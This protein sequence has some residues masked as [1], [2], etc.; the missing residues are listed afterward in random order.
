MAI[1]NTISDFVYHL[2]S[3]RVVYNIG[4]PIDRYNIFGIMFGI[5]KREGEILEDLNGNGA[6]RIAYYSTCLTHS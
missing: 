4:I 5:H 3:Y 1:G 6:C 2:L